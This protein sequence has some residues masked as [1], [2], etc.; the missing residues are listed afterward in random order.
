MGAQRA[1]ALVCALLAAAVMGLWVY[2]GLTK[3]EGFKLGTNSQVFVE[4]TAVDAFGDEVKSRVLVDN[5]DR[6]DLGL[7]RAGPLAGALGALAVGLF[8]WG[9]R[10]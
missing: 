2:K 7:D 8:V 9:R 4:Q 5:P 10:G 1:G 3:P 6:L